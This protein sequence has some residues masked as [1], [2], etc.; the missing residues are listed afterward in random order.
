MA[1]IT[2]DGLFY[3]DRVKKLSLMA[4]LYWP[5]FFVASNTLGRIELN[6]EKLSSTAFA[7]LP[8]KPT[9]DE[10][11]GF[12]GEYYTAHLLFTYDS[13]GQIWGQWDTDQALLPKHKLA[14]DKR[15]PDPPKEAWDGWIEQYKKQKH[16]NR[17]KVFDVT[18]FVLPGKTSLKVP[19][20]SEIL[21][22]VTRGIG[23]GVGGGDGKARVG[24]TLSAVAD[25]RFQP[26]IEDLDKYWVKKNPDVPFSVSPA[27][28]RNLKQFLRDNPKVDRELFRKCLN[29]RARSPGMVHSQ[30]IHKWIL[31]ILEFAHGT[32]DRF[33]KPEN[34]AGKSDGLRRTNASAEAESLAA[35]GVTDADREFLQAGPIA[36]GAESLAGTVDEVPIREGP[37][38]VEGSH[39]LTGGMQVLSKARTGD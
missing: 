5:R 1:I 25:G 10:F 27:D 34:S 3:G 11:W 8:A 26:F 35:L 17:P 29:N 6:Y 19:E 28:G 15:T 16:D 22:K 32:L 24:K 21:Q 36:S 14:A 7:S 39:G 38:S 30:K 9:V 13:E 12:V 23:V 33:N 2:Q 37:R 20:S 4:Q 31:S 18:C